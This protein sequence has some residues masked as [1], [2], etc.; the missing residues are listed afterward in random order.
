MERLAKLSSNRVFYRRRNVEG[1]VLPS[2]SAELEIEIEENM[3]ALVII[4]LF[5]W[6]NWIISFKITD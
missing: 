5:F 6:R 4:L 1:S 3:D 2:G